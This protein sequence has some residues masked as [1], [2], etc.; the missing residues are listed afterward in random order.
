MNDYRQTLAALQAAD[1]SFLAS[2][3]T[4]KSAVTANAPT[5]KQPR[6]SRRRVKPT[7]T[8]TANTMDTI[9]APIVTTPI[10]TAPSPK[11]T[12]PVH[13]HAPR[14]FPTTEPELPVFVPPAQR[15]TGKDTEAANGTVSAVASSTPTMTGVAGAM[16]VGGPPKKQR[17]RP[18]HEWPPVGTRLRGEYFGTVYHAEIVPA[19]K[20]LKSGKQI[21]LLDGPAQGKRLDSYTKAAL[22]ATTRQRRANKLGR[23]GLA[24]GWTFWTAIPDPG[25]PPEGTP[26]PPRNNSAT[27]P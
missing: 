24:S 7:S 19:R 1:L 18:S 10:S 9:P 8:A 11:A 3:S 13:M 6:Q 15:K 2:E 26:C 25:T 5:G 27:S 22:V 16:E 4:T 23:K 14:P 17:N 12:T 21:R 20:M